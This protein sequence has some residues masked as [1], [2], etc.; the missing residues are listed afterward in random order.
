LTQKIA[1][2]RIG[3]LLSQAH[4]DFWESLPPAK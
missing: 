2:V 4:P 3:G 1:P